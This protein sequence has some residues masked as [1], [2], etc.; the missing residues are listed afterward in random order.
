MSEV[1]VGEITTAGVTWAV[2]F[3]AS[4]HTFAATADGFNE[5]HGRTWDGLEAQCKTRTSQ[6]RVKV[7]VPFAVVGGRRAY[8]KDGAQWV[9]RYLRQGMA[10]GIHASSGKVLASI[11]GKNDQLSQ[12]SRDYFRV[13]DEETENRLVEL[14][15]TIVTLQ[16]DRDA[17]LKTLRFADDN[18]REVYLG[19]IVRQEVEKARTA[20]TKGDDGDAEKGD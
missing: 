6:A 12:Y 15:N 5:Q 13:P 10:T 14:E 9:E 1:P 18:G 7:R 19:D 3:D 16:N 17:I 8:G 4:R 20:R 2:T 11:E